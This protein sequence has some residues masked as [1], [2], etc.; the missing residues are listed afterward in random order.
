MTFDVSPEESISAT[1]DFVLTSEKIRRIARERLSDWPA[2]ATAYEDPYCIIGVWNFATFSDLEESWLNAQELVA[3]LVSANV[4]SLDAKSWDGYLVLVTS[5]RA[6]PRQASELARIRNNTR[7]IRKIVITGD[8]LNLETEES[9]RASLRRQLGA[10]LPLHLEEHLG[11]VDPFID[12]PSRVTSASLGP[13][14]VR[15]VLDAR[16]SGKPMIAALHDLLSRTHGQAS[17]GAAP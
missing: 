12:L 8:D 1:V 11:T 17:E 6:G 16:H 7:R 9:L 14:E 2:T 13:G 15:C 4:S 3:D 5:G 10:L